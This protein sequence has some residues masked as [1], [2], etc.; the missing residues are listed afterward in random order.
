M[1]KTIA[2][3]LGSFG[4]KIGSICITMMMTLMME[5]ILLLGLPMCRNANVIL[6]SNKVRKFWETLLSLNLHRRGHPAWVSNSHSTSK[7]TKTPRKN[8]LG[9]KNPEGQNFQKC[10]QSPFPTTSPIWDVSPTWQISRVSLTKCVILWNVLPSSHI[11]NCSNALSG[12][13]SPIIR[14]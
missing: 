12:V 9:P 6:L 11:G 5:A 8:N 14:T 3:I 4:L 1:K 10:P 13:I 7:T 2:S